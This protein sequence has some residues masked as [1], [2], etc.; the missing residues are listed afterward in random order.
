V[1]R[2]WRNAASRKVWEGERPNYGMRKV[3][4]ILGQLDDADVEWMAE[5]GHRERVAD[6]QVLIREGQEIDAIYLVLEGAVTVDVAGLG[7]IARLGCGEGVGEMSLVDARPTSARVTASG[8]GQVL[9][10]D[11]SVLRD[12]VMDGRRLCLTVLSRDRELSRRSPAR[13][14]G[15]TGLWRGRAPERG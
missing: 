4:Y 10:L 15:P 11:R 2:S 1:I 7:Q 8:A 6:G 3:L 14:G 9:R 12:R 13:H 5:V